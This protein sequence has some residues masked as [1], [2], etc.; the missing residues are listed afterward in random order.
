MEPSMRKEIFIG[1]ASR[2]GTTLL[3]SMLGTHSQ[4]ITTPESQFKFNLAPW[5]EGSEKNPD[6]IYRELV[7]NNRF[8]IWKI[9]PDQSVLNF[10]KLSTLVHDLVD[11]YV[12]AN[13]LHAY[14]YW[15]DHTP[16]NLRHADFLDKAFPNC[17]FI[18]LVRDGRAVY[19]SQKSL[20]IGANDPFF[21][22]IK[23][24]EALAS[25]LLCESRFPD[26]CLRIYY[27][28]LVREPQKTCTKICEFIGVSFE[29]SM[30]AGDGFKVPSYTSKQHRL[31]GSL[32]D[33]SRIDNWQQIVTDQ[34]VL[35][36][37]SMT[38]DMLPMLGYK[39][40]NQGIL[41]K[42]S[43]IRQG[44]SMIKGAIKY[45]TLDKWRMRKR[46]KKNI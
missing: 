25:G 23:W 11:M 7:N 35:F 46:M 34:E 15:V 14:T 6:A 21:A 9:N 24:T 13:Q 19:A 42:P 41:P 2:S 43:E 20:D 38:Y 31:I 40:M 28:D 10:A 32:P 44:L 39:K 37:E 16:V 17:Y 36:F 45:I 27:E 33:A 30:L 26:R 12:K 5:F 29:E 8:K 1:G 3:G 4:M 18:H 22:A